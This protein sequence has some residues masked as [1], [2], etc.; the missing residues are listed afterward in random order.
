MTV[1]GKNAALPYFLLVDNEF[2]RLHR[3]LRSASKRNDQENW[4]KAAHKFAENVTQTLQH[5]VLCSDI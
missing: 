1:R 5:E 4:Q 2:H 3:I